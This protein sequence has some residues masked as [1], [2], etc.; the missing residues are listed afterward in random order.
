MLRVNP[1]PNESQQQSEIFNEK[2]LEFVDTM[3]YLIDPDGMV[4]IFTKMMEDG[5]VRVNMFNRGVSLFN[6]H[7]L[8][9]T[10]KE[11]VQQVTQELITVKEKADNE[12][13]EPA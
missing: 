7:G 2:C 4:F 6:L 8:A 1:M 5:T 11:L 10:N 3:D 13:V 12:Q 9:Q